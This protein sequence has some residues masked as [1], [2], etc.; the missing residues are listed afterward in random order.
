MNEKLTPQQIRARA[1][2]AKNAERI[3]TQKRAKYHS[4]KATEKPLKPTEKPLK[5]TEKPLKPIPTKEP[6]GEVDVPPL[7]QE[8]LRPR[9]LSARE[10]IENMRIAQECGASGDIGGDW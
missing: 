6:L 7:N 8:E 10:R 1:Y 5:T 3:K 9:A 4:K 2:Y